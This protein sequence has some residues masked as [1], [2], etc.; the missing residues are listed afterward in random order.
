MDHTKDHQGH[1]WLI[2]GAAVVALLLGFGIGWA[3]T[4]ALLVCAATLA[5]VFWVGRTSGR[6][7]RGRHDVYQR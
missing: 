7:P 5:V 4:V 3:I 1:M 6:S 2:G